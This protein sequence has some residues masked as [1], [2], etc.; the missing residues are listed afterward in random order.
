MH[1]QKSFKEGNPKGG[2]MHYQ[3][4]DKG[5]KGPKWEHPLCFQVIVHQ[6]FCSEKFL[7]LLWILTMTPFLLSFVPLL[8]LYSFCYGFLQMGTG[9]VCSLVQHICRIWKTSFYRNPIHLLT[10]RVFLPSLD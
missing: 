10:T 1:P 3:S 7:W 6:T 9:A 2:T 5:V 4:C 8:S